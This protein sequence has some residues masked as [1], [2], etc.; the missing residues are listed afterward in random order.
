MVTNMLVAK[1]GFKVILWI[2][3]NARKNSVIDVHFVYFDIRVMHVCVHKQ[4]NVRD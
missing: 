2:Y 4:C 1:V 3:E